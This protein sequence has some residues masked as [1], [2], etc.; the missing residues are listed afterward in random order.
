MAKTCPRLDFGTAA[1]NHAGAHAFDSASAGATIGPTRAYVVMPTGRRWAGDGRNFSDRA[2]KS[3][4]G[5][6]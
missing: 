4:S 1:A 3:F 6:E 5:A 2:S